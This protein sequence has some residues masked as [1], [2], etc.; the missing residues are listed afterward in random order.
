[1][2]AAVKS[3]DAKKV[4]ELMRQDPGFNVNMDHGSGET[5]LHHACYED[6][7]SAVIPLLLAHPDIDVNVKDK[8]GQTPFLWACNGDLSCVREMLKDSRGKVNELTKDG[9]MDSTLV[10]CSLWLP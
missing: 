8:Y 10:G 3:G 7:R 6:S 4:A 9:W 1:M 5:L 2:E